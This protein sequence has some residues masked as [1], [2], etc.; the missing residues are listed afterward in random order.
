[1]YVVMV[2]QGRAAGRSEFAIRRRGRPAAIS[3]EIRAK[4]KRK[5][6][7][8]IRNERCER[9]SLAEEEEKSKETRRRV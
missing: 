2:F 7:M 5:T 4:R 9:A 8:A 1:M 6:K 3:N